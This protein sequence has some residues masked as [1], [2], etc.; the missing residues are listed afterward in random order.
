MTGSPSTPLL[1]V[2]AGPA[3]GRS[4]PIDRSVTIGRDDGNTLP[5][6][7]PALSRRHCVVDPGG[8]RLVIRD[9]G[10]RNGVFVNGRP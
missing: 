7:D 3:R 10:S 9:L 1:I 8:P 4:V 5:I 2:I 6:V